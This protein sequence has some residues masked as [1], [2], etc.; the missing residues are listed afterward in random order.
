VLSVDD[1]ITLFRRIAGEGRAGD[2]DQVA[3][4][5]GLCGRLPLA[6]QLTASRIAQNGPVSLDGL[7]EELSQS[8]AWLGGAGAASPEV[9]AAFDLSYRALEP[10]HQRF[11]RR[12][13]I[14]PCP[15]LSPPAA[16]ALDDC[17]VAEAEKAL[18][19]LLDCH[20]LARAP[21]GQFRFHDLIRGYAAVRAARDDPEAEQRRAVGRLLDYYLHTADQADRVLHQF[22]RRTP[23]QTTQLPA[24]SPALGTEEDAAGWLESEWRNI[25]QAARHAGRHEWQQKC[26][27]LIHVLAYFVEIKAYWDEAIAAHT[28]ARQACRDL[29][30]PARIAQA[31]LAL[32]AVLQ[33]TG[34]HEAA[35]PL[36]EEAAAIYRLLADRRGEA[37]SLDQIGLAY[38]RTARSREALAYFHEARIL[39]RTAECPRGVADTLSHSGIACWHL[40]RYPE[41]SAHL[42]DALSLYRDVGDRRGEAKA[43]N[44]L[45]RIHLYNGYHR[46]AL[47]A[48]QKSLQIFREI[49]GA[50]NEAILYHSIGSVHHYKGSYEEG[51]A[52]CRRALAIYRDIGDLPDEA[53][54]LNDIGAIY[55][56]AACHDE[57]LIHHQK[58]Q[59]IAEE[60]GNLSQQLIAL[61]KIAD[62]HRGSGRYEEALDHYHTALTLAREIGDPY[63][64]GKILEGIAES[65]LNTQRQPHAARIVFRQALDIFERLGVPEA[66]SAR[67]RIETM[68]PAFGLSVS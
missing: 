18:V 7:I 4:T 65:T 31:S 38:Q 53:D 59:L 29:A 26:A 5:V 14:S 63:E 43:L 60:I 68:D 41:A 40:G 45:G 34:R 42:R 13:G 23:V 44:N 10:D 11:F 66:E 46:G 52:A 20:L 2:A 37:E 15:C 54:V 39:Y 64:E 48:Y 49:G 1:A 67:I 50:Q 57:A 55:L 21:D 6:I 33:Q 8:P 17:S 61:R 24:A 25:L 3:V 56:S 22:R 51:L 35:L 32:S 16:A 58:A 47:D 30:D 28:L 62:I 12:L 19:T 9:I 27:D 36:A